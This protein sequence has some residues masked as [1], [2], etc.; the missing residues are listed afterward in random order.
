LIIGQWSVKVALALCDTPL[1]YVAVWYIRRYM[2]M[3]KTY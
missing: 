3:E 1:V 2:V